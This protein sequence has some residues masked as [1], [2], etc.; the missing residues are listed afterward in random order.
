MSGTRNGLSRKDVFALIQATV[1]RVP[2]SMA[3]SVE[4]MVSDRT[5][6]SVCS[7][8]GHFLLPV[9]FG[10][11]LGNTV[12][13]FDAIA[14]GLQ[15]SYFPSFHQLLMNTLL[16]K[17]G[18]VFFFLMIIPVFLHSVLVPECFSCLAKIPALPVFLAS[19]LASAALV[20]GFCRK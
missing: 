16:S 4:E 11:Q 20:C 9:E 13:C 17:V 6:P 5:L 18:T 12:R 8:V 14:D 1:A 19:T 7:V 10:F 3:L 15:P 2:G